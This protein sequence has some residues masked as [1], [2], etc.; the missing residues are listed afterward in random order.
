MS[1]II[2]VPNVLTKLPEARQRFRQTFDQYWQDRL[3]SEIE[4]QLRR[5][6][7]KGIVGIIYARL[8]N[9]KLG[10][11]L[12]VPGLNLVTSDGD[13]YYAQ[14]GVQETPTNDYTGVNAGIRLGT[15][16]TGPTK[17][18][19]DVQTFIT[20]SELA[21]DA[22]YPKRNDDDTNNSGRGIT[23]MTWRYSYLAAAGP[24][25]NIAEGAIAN[26]RTTPGNLLTRFLFAGPFSKTTSDTLV[27]YVN[28][29]VLGV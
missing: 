26:N 28:H 16:T 13:L 3:Q 21:V 27:V 4:H 14:R 6:G 19:A 12:M 22:T 5:Q 20:G 18:D 25:N 8:E 23:V 9:A 7:T 1:K 2:E 24:F 10:E 29:T 17:S 11:S 15:G